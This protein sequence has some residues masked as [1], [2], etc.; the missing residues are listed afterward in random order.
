MTTSVTTTVEFYLSVF[1]FSGFLFFK[2][3][4]QNHSLSVS[5]LADI[6]MWC[7]H[8]PGCLGN[9]KGVGGGVGYKMRDGV[10]GWGGMS[11]RDLKFKSFL[12]QPCLRPTTN[13]S[14]LL[15]CKIIIKRHSP[16]VWTPAVCY[17]HRERS[18]FSELRVA[19]LNIEVVS[20]CVWVF[21][22]VSV[23]VN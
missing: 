9:R 17:T 8:L 10:R 6:C 18:V 1:R 3:R 7:H 23:S 5:S 11:R 14:S 12:Q 22:L 20:L 2:H 13:T 4:Y 19:G 21:F 16:A 15:W